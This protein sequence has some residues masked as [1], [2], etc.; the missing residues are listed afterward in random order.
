MVR[1]AATP[2]IS[3]HEA[4]CMPDD[5]DWPNLENAL[6]GSSAG[7]LDELV[8]Q[9]L[10]D[11]ARDV[12]VNR[13]HRLAHGGILFRRQRD[14]FGLAGFLDRLK[15]VFVFLRRLPV[16]LG[17]GFLHGLLELCKKIGRENRP[18]TLSPPPHPRPLSPL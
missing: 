15:R 5:S 13:L 12:L 16:A 17:G 4:R 11:P 8:D 18:P 1:S 14:D 3:N 6:V 7:F 9:R 10:T 2:R